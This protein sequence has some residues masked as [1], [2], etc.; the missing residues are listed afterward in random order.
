M[1]GHAVIV[2]PAGQLLGQHHRPVAS[3]GAPHGHRQIGLALADVGR[4]QHGEELVQLGQELGRLGPVED[5]LPHLGLEAAVAAQRLV[6]VGVGQEP[7]VEHQVDVTG[8]SVLEPERDDGG[9]HRASGFSFAEHLHQPCPQLVAVELAGVDDQVGPIT[10][11]AEQVPLVGDGVHDAPG[12]LRVTPPGAFE[13]SD[14]HVVGRVQEQDPDPVP[15]RLESVDR[16]QHVIEITSA[17]TDHE[18]HPLQLRARAVDELGH[19]GDQGRRHVVDHEPAQVLERGPGRGPARAGHAGH[20]QVFAHRLTSACR[21]VGPL[22][23]LRRV[24]ALE[25]R[26][27]HVSR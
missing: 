6:P 21:S 1:V 16:R 5:E 2:E 18:R 11:S 25:Y 13:P 22:P 4:D 10:Q 14:Q 3:A 12:G 27:T 9:L 17:P 19:L 24:Q 15:A 26:C 8:S 23:G 20:H 7:A